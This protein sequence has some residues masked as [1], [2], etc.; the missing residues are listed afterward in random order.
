MLTKTTKEDIE[1]YVEMVNDLVEDSQ[2]KDIMIKNKPAIIAIV[3]YACMEDI[4]L[5]GLFDELL[6]NFTF[7]EDQ[8]EN[9]IYVR[10]KLRGRAYEFNA[11]HILPKK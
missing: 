11:N 7:S 2:P 6:L 4:D 9:Y 3:A 10:E 8:K 1:L 5:D